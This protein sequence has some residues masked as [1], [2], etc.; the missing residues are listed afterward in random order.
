MREYCKAITGSISSA[1]VVCDIAEEA[2]VLIEALAKGAAI[3]DINSYLNGMFELA[4]KGLGITTK[5]VSDFKKIRAD[6]ISA[7]SFL[8]LLS[9]SLIM[10]ID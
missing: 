8:V 1:Q 7:S 9:W 6:V 10:R 2:K 5:T 4:E 3:A